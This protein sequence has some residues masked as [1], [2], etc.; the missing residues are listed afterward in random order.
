MKKLIILL[1]LI[2]SPTFAAMSLSGL[3]GS[4][5]VL[6]ANEPSVL[7]LGDSITMGQGEDGLWGTG[8]RGYLYPILGGYYEFVGNLYSRSYPVDTYLP[9][10][11]ID[12]PYF[13][14]YGHHEGVSGEATAAVEARTLSVLGRALPK[15]VHPDSIVLLHV[16]TNDRT[17][18]DTNGS[19]AGDGD[20]TPSVQNVVDIINIIQAYDSNISIY[21]AL[22]IPADYDVADWRYVVVDT[23][24]TLLNS[25][26][27]GLGLTGVYIVDMNAAF[28]N[29][30]NCATIGD[31]MNNNLHPNNAGY[32]VMANTWATSILANE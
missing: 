27:T 11:A 19:G 5:V 2:A 28:K 18:I 17:V 29:T 16:G 24:N 15:P 14:Q 1:L 6:S 4:G 12:E 30:S 13:T 7:A 32:K 25:T 22:I 31:C 9:A 10:T 26:L 20:A 3:T 21:V 8:Y 23:F